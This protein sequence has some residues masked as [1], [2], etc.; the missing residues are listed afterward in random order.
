MLRL[1]YRFVVPLPIKENEL[2]DFAPP[3]WEE[4]QAAGLEIVDLDPA[5]VERSFELRTTFGTLSAEDCFSLSLA[6]SLQHSMLLT[7]DASLRK[8]ADSLEVNVHG[9]L[10]VIDE[11]HR[12]RLT[13]PE[14]LAKCLTTWRD[15]PL[16]WLPAALIAARL[17][18]LGK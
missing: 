15:D 9:V 16:V 8:V 5:Q 14:Q 18:L 17:R 2:L 10:W 6:E 4:L 3:E 12:L 11:L 1:P 7:S 13:P